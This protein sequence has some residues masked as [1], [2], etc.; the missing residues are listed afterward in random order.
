MRVSFCTLICNGAFSL[1]LHL[2]YVRWE[3]PSYNGPV[4][5][6][7]VEVKFLDMALYSSM[8]YPQYR[9]DFFCFVSFAALEPTQPTVALR[10]L[11]K[12]VNSNI[13]IH[14]LSC[15]LLVL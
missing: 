3:P 15:L 5:K 14:H 13:G 1:T 9:A 8:L 2:K 6:Q 10:M 7:T 11:A 4:T 12:H